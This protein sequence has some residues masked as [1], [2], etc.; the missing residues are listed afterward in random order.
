MSSS[1][2]ADLHPS[3]C[4][5][6][7]GAARG[8]IEN[9]HSP[10]S[11]RVALD[12][13]AGDGADTIL[14]MAD[15]VSAREG[16]WLFRRGQLVAGIAAAPADTDLPA[17]T[18]DV[19]QR[20]FA[21]T[22]G[23]HLYR[24]WNYVPH[25][26]GQEHG[27]ENYQRFCRGRSLA[28]EREFGTDF[29]RYLP[30]ASAV[31][32]G[33]GPLTLAFLAGSCVPAHFENPLQLPAFQ[34]PAAH[35]PRPPSFSR[36]TAVQTD[37]GSLIFISGTAAIRGHASVAPGDLDAQISCT[38]ENLESIGQ[39]CGIGPTLGRDGSWQRTFKIYM[40]QRESLPRVIA[41]VGNQLCRPGDHVLYLQADIC[42]S[43]LLF[44]IEASLAHPK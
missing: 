31:G 35:G 1:A 36:A 7:F 4:R 44:E 8:E 23:M 5:V 17:A 13:L 30:A 20:L 24:I 43:E 39:A 3:A 41:R 12:P 33:A 19:Y 6:V 42:R 34:Y 11:L 26:N 21:V 16:I 27:V 22:R 32:T 25:I 14:P 37:S 38:V 10:P 28:F 15:Q 9:L 29:Q 18:R 40:R 2:S